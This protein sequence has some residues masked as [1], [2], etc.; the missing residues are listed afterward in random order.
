MH[1]RVHAA[2]LTSLQNKFMGDSSGL[3]V[4]SQSAVWEIEGHDRSKVI[5]AICRFAV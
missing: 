1:L 4:A 2:C 5:R 3:T